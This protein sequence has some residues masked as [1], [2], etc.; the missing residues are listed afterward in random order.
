M[1]WATLFVALRKSR[2]HSLEKPDTGPFTP[3][4]W[5][6]AN[7]MTEPHN[8]Q[9]KQIEE[10]LDGCA[11][12]GDSFFQTLRHYDDS[13][14]CK[15]EELCRY[16]NCGKHLVI[17]STVK[18]SHVVHAVWHAFRCNNPGM[19][20]TV[21]AHVHHSAHTEEDL[22]NTIGLCLSPGK[23]QE[24]DEVPGNQPFKPELIFQLEREERLMMETQRDG[25]SG[26]KS[27]HNMESIQEVGLSC[28]SPKAL[29][30]WQSWQQGAGRLTGCQDS[31]RNFQENI[32][33]LQKQDD[34]LC[35]VWGGIPIQISED[36]NYVLTHIGDGSND[37]KSQEFPS[38][39]AHHSWRKMYL[40]ESRN[41]QCRCQQVS[42]ENDFCKSD[43]ISWISHHSDNLGV[44]RTGKNSSCHDCGEDVMKVSL[45]NHIQTGQKPY[46]GNEYRKAF[47]DDS[48]SEVHQQLDLEGKPRTYSPCEKDCSYR[49]VLHIHQ[50]VCRG[51]H[52]VFENS[53]LQSHQKGHAKEKP[54]KCEYRES[55]NQC[56]SHNTYEL[57]PGGETSDRCSMYEKGFSHSLDLSSIVRVYIEEESHESEEKGNVFNENSCLQ[58]H[59]KI[60]TEE[61]RY[62]D[63]E[64]EK[65]VIGVE[66][67]DHMFLRSGGLLRIEIIFEKINNSAEYGHQS[68]KPDMISQLEREEK[69]WTIEIQPQRGGRSAMENTLQ[70][71]M[72]GE[73]MFLRKRGSEE[74]FIT[75][76]VCTGLITTMDSD[77]S[78]DKKSC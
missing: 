49:S 55:I 44:H 13:Q 20:F 63:V 66:L 34:S 61:K 36:E 51:D 3:E 31:M 39:R 28:F 46:P 77:E 68:S 6:K 14:E 42:T 11:W 65:G 10:K 21:D 57:I 48:S 32:S 73:E 43:S 35:Q 2:H 67:L 64:C 40:T 22:I 69:F 60:H 7:L 16:T 70:V 8:S 18:H 75:L 1:L 62:T 19:G 50:S 29:S 58:A 78:E 47:S 15:G 17:K 59:Q 45:L 76:I 12:C 54:F 24:D 74:I 38:W 27:P 25:C 53:H 9:R 26:T 30:T 33:Q 72:T 71:V 5:K 41:C 37:I 56:S 52:C 23:G 4:S